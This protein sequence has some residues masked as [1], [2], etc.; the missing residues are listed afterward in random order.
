M[1]AP[2]LAFNLPDD[3]AVDAELQEAYETILGA[4]NQM[5]NLH[6]KKFRSAQMKFKNAKT[7]EDTLQAIEE[8]MTHVVVHD[9]LEN[10]KKAINSK[11]CALIYK[12]WQQEDEDT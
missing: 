11:L 5:I 10:D 4:M 9:T 2:T 12:H 8:M 1:L 7:K 3:Q 6:E